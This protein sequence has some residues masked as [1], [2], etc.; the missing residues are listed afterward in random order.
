MLADAT[1]VVEAHADRIGWLVAQERFEEAGIV[2]DRLGG[3]LRGAS[4][5]QKFAPLA[6]CAELVA[7]K[8]ADDG[9][10]ELVLVRHGRLAGTA[11]VDR[12]TDPRPAIATLQATG[13]QVEAPVAPAPAAHPEETD[14]ILAWLEKP[15]V[16][17]V[18]VDRPWACPVRSAEALGDPATAVATLV[19]P[20][21]APEGGRL[22]QLVAGPAGERE[23]DVAEARPV[24]LE[25]DDARV[26][27]IS[28]RAPRTA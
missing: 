13:E 12:R 19:R 25:I 22:I 17:L 5:A 9:G 24:T 2:R 3:F 18:A 20:R 10:W 27:P 26:I 1:P 15:G 4:R 8:R 28:I 16:R 11:R 7:A 14:L 23:L 6:A 21:L